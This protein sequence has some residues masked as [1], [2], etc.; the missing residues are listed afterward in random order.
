[1][2]LSNHNS[3]A[4]LCIEWCKSRARSRQ[5][6]EEVTLLLEEM[7]RVSILLEWAADWWVQQTTAMSWIGLCTEGGFGSLRQKI[8]V[9][10]AG[11]ILV[12]FDVWTSKSGDPYPSW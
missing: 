3:Y 10:L 8:G 9:D 4:V 6:S 5:W 2:Y 7:G 11:L 12:T 1:M